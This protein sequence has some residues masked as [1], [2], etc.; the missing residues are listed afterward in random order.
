[1]IDNLIDLFPAFTLIVNIILAVFLVYWL[2]FR[3]KLSSKL[4]Y[5]FINNG[6]L[7]AFIFAVFA[8]T[9]SL[10]YSEYALYQPCKLCWYQRIFM[11]PQ[12]IILGI[13][14]WKKY[15]S[16]R[17]YSIIFSVIGSIFALYHYLTQRFPDLIST[18][19]TAGEVDCSFK[20]GFDYG[21]ITIP[22]MSL[23]AF[24]FIIVF[25]SIWKKKESQV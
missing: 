5:F 20:Y 6:L 3:N 9:G 8:T 13:A 19:C 11:Y 25:I 7:I 12:V 14:L 16:A 15:I 1:M 22:I 10:L 18:G 21:Y 23:T 17:L 4:K 24:I 2:I